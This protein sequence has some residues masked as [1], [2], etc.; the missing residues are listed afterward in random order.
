[1]SQRAEVQVAEVDPA[2]VRRWLDDG[3][4]VLVD[5]RETS[6]YEQEH[7]PGSV[8]VPLSVFDPDLFPRIPGK[9]LVI[10]CAVGKR[11]AAAGKQ[12]LQ[13]GHARVHNLR[14][15][16]QAWKGAG[17][18]TEV[19][20]TPPAV[21]EGIPLSAQDRRSLEAA[22][23]GEHRDAR[24]PPHL[25][26]GEVLRTEF[27]EPL[28]LSQRQV[29]RDLGIAPRRI[30]DLVRGRRGVTVDTALRLARYFS[31]SEEFWLRLQ[32]DHE[33]ERAHGAIGQRIRRE[34]MPR[35]SR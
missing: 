35:G 9:K 32:M 17:Y 8:L 6:E 4:A 3:E 21:P 22:A 27:L 29:A 34:V 28:G 23:A 2:T 12:L 11:S 25:H 30:G 20:F 19:Q 31:T 7:I 5:V 10:H 33:L 13:A 1:M 16:I 24:T 14:G 26:P 18:A 15:G